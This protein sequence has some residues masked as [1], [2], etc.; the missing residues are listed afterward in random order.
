MI[1]KIFEEPIIEVM[2]F[3]VQDVVTTSGEEPTV[4]PNFVGPCVQ[5]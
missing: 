1:M 4:T 3:E 5:M 2:N